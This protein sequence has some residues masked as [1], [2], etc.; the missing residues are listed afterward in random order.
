MAIVEAD[1]DSEKELERWVKNEFSTFLPASVLL[2]GFLASTPAG[3]KGVPD[4]FAFDFDGRQWSVIECE[5]LK[6]GVWPHIAEQLT[7]F[8]VAMKNSATLRIVRDR[9]FE[10]IMDSGTAAEVAKQL[11]CVPERL[12]QEIELFVEGIRPQFVVFIDTINKDLQDMAAA[13]DAPTLVFR[14]QKFLVD[15]RP[16]YHSPDRNLPTIATEP[17]EAP[18]GGATEYDVVEIL[19]AYPITSAARS[20]MYAQAKC[21]MAA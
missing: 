16:E 3:K 21:S 13:L 12:L 17:E 1:F 20:V 14:V 5:L 10:H 2:D 7:R 15:G 9:L 4:G 19:G 8:V 6:H 18:G 11:D